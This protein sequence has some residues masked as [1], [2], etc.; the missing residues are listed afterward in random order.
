MTL[1]ANTKPES[2]EAQFEHGVLHVAIAKAGIVKP[3]QI[4]IGEGKPGLISKILGKKEEK[5]A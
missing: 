4:Q 2:I 3:Q 5:A 1:P